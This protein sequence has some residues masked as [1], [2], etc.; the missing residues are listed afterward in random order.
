M[1]TLLLICSL[2]DFIAFYLLDCTMC[3]FN[4]RMR[5]AVDLCFKLM[6]GIYHKSV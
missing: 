5:V 2:V 3:L 6:N 4:M 1:L